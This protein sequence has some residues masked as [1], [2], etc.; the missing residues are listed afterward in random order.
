MPVIFVHGVNTRADDPAYGAR[1][2][3]IET[4]MRHAL[5]GARVNGRSLPDAKPT[6]AYWGDLAATFAWQMQSLPSGWREALG[7]DL[8]PDLRASIA[9]LYDLLDDPGDARDEPLLALANHSFPRAVDLLTEL[10]LENASGTQVDDAA[11]FAAEVQLYASR[12]E[13][14]GVRPAWLDGLVTDAQFCNL[15]VHALTE[16]TA[17]SCGSQALGSTS[18]GFNH[19]V[20][21]AMGR[22]RQATQSAAGTALDRSGDFLSTRT[23]AWTRAS[24]N[25]TLGRFFGDIFVYFNGRGDKEHPG[26]I[27]ER[28]MSQW[29]PVIDAATDE[30]LIIVGHSLG[31]V[32]SYDLLTHFQNDLVVDLFVSVGSQVAHFEEMKLYKASQDG[33]PGVLGRTVPK[34]SNIRH[35]INVY[36]EVDIF[37]YS[38]EK[39]FKDVI[40]HPYDTRTY[41]VKAHG[42][43]L[44]QA[45]FYERLR[46][47]IDALPA[48]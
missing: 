40:D 41:V 48:L 1:C 38:C 34:H 33:Y 17:A 15:L 22:F 2:A 44:V 28:I 43:Y 5:S 47:R 42:A 12:F 24:L 21:S 46:T 35:W 3:L 26:A 45:R 23:L 18:G 19:A 31:G 27:P 39:I 25:A 4:L 16:K 6:F 14:S 10:V 11:R 8:A 36:D 32:I 29:Q 7:P 30:P 13:A 37:S 20:I 9:M